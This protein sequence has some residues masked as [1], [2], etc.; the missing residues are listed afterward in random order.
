MRK[1]ETNIDITIEKK[2][3]YQNQFNHQKLS[4]ELSNYIDEECKGILR[5]T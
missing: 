2:E 1:K 3:D 5:F 4:K